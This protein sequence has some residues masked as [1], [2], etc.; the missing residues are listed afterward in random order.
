MIKDVSCCRTMGEI[1]QQPKAIAL[2]QDFEHMPCAGDQMAEFKEG[3]K[4]TLNRAGNP[5]VVR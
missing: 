4:I 1:G 5:Q 2:L 3:R